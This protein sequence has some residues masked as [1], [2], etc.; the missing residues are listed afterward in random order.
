MKLSR[1]KGIAHD[2]A[3]HL[4]W[5][6]FTGYWKDLVFP[7]RRDALKMEDSFDKFCVDFFKERL[8]K[9]FDFKRVKEIKMSIIRSGT[10]MDI[11]IQVKVDD[12]KFTGQSH[13]FSY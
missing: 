7:I 8:P 10:K 5:Q 12:K 11:L 1:F 4:S 9:T 2:L 3:S 6:L 13:V